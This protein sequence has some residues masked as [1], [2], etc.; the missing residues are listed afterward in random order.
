MLVRLLKTKKPVSILT[1]LSIGL[2]L[3]IFT[4]FTPAIATQPSVQIQTNPLNPAFID[5]L[6]HHYN[7]DQNI[8]T[9]SLSGPETAIHQT[10]LAGIITLQRFPNV[11]IINL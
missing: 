5:Y 3:L 7:S 1:L 8:A 2:L 10:G 11:D 4:N 6:N 9:L